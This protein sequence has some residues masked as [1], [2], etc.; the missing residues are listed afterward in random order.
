MLSNRA[1]VVFLY[2][3]DMLLLLY[4]FIPGKLLLP[5]AR[6]AH[7]NMYLIASTLVRLAIV[8]AECRQ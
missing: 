1:E 4:F 3:W 8:S 7:T 2:H 6:D 5:P